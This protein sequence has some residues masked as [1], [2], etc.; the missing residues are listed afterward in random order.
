MDAFKPDPPTVQRATQDC[1]EKYGEE[2][3]RSLERYMRKWLP[4]YE[5]LSQFKA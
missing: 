5:Y 4:D 1:I 2:V 3:G